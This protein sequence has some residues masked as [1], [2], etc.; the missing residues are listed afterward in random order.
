MHDACERFTGWQ[1]VV[2]K[3]MDDQSIDAAINMNVKEMFIYKPLA[4]FFS[5]TEP[6]EH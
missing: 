6:W 1:M 3:N 4:V 2:D 5:W